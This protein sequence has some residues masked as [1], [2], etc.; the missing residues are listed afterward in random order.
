MT[1][2]HNE[3]LTLIFWL[4]LGAIAITAFFIVFP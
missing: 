3:M 4:R 1:Q 2:W